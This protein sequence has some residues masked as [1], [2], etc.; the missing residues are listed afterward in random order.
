MRVTPEPGLVF[1]QVRENSLQQA[2]G[3]V[4]RSAAE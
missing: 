4:T 3:I 2:L 1:E